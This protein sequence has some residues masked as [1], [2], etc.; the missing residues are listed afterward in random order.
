[1]D[2][3]EDGS[4]QERFKVEINFQFVKRVGNIFT[5]DD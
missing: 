2:F 5:S 3:Q 1:M 4:P